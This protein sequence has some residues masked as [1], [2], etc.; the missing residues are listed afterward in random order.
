MADAHDFLLRI[1]GIVDESVDLIVG[2]DVFEHEHDL[3]IGATMEG[4][5]ERTNG[6][7]DVAIVIARSR[8]DDTSG[9]GRCVQLMIG[10]KN[11]SRVEES[12]FIRS[13]FFAANHVEEV[14]GNRFAGD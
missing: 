10:M 6:S 12:F 5:L 14:P 3:L 2:A 7:R 11:E 1:D 13:G 4:T 8:S 9:E